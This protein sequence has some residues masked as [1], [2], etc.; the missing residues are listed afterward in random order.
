[1]QKDIEALDELQSPQNIN[2]VNKNKVKISGKNVNKLWQKLFN[3]SVNTG[4]DTKLGLFES[5]REK[6]SV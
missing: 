1:M 2:N 6:R 5:L 3:A 4:S